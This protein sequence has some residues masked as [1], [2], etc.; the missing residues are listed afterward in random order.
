[1]VGLARPT[2]AGAQPDG[3]LYRT[4]A[5]RLVGRATRD[6]PTLSPHRCWTH[7]WL[8]WLLCLRTSLGRD[9]IICVSV[10]FSD[11]Q[12]FQSYSHIRPSSA[13]YAR[14]WIN[15]RANQ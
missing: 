8:T 15:L 10:P 11:R 9:Y 4:Y 1:M 5:T 12:E 2:D 7:L 3:V 14:W 13:F 6:T